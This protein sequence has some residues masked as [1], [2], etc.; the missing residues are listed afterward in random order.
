MGILG[1][2]DQRPLETMSGVWGKRICHQNQSSMCNIRV[3]AQ[4]VSR[5][6]IQLVALGWKL[7]P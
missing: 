4:S 6:R 5:V 1:S 3:K 2:N 7:S